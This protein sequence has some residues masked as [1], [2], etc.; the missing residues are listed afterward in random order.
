MILNVGDILPPD[1]DIEQVVRLGAW[2][3]EFGG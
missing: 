1:G 3:R 2:A